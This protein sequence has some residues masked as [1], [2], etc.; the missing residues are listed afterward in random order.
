MEHFRLQDPPQILRQSGIQRPKIP[1]NW[2]LDEFS[3]PGIHFTLTTEKKI[4]VECLK[5]LPNSAARIDAFA[6]AW[7]NGFD[8]RDIRSRINSRKSSFVG[9]VINAVTRTAN[10][11]NGHSL[12]VTV[13]MGPMLH[14]LLEHLCAL[15]AALDEDFQSIDSIEVSEFYASGLRDFSDI[16]KSSDSL[17]VSNEQLPSLADFSASILRSNLLKS[18]TAEQSNDF[19][20]ILSDLSTALK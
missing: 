16:L 14:A 2:H 20:A 7:R 8:L 4:Y 6:T 5:R 12:K 15:E 11:S 13:N 10:R 9:T 17:T 18:T 19:L 1:K 3:A